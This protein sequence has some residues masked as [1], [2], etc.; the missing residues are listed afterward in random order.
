M[1]EVVNGETPD[2][3]S[4]GGPEDLRL[5]AAEWGLL[6]LLAAMQF[7]HIVDF[8]IIMPL[9]PVYIEK[10][11]LRPD[12]FG[13]MVSAYTISA[14]LAS[15]LAARFLD[16]FDRKITLLVLYAGFTVGTLLCAAAPTFV[17][18]VAARTV[19]GAFGGVTAAVVYAIVGDAFPHARRGTAMSVLMY[20]FSVATIFGVPIGLI[21]A[22]QLG[23]QAP[24]VVLGLLSV[25]MLAVGAVVLPPLR[26]HLDGPR[27]EEVSTWEVAF[28]PNHV[29]AFLLMLALV[30][31]S[32][33]VFPFVSTFLTFNVHM[34]QAYLKYMYLCGGLTTL[35]TLTLFGR[36]A[37]RFGKLRVFRIAAVACLIPFVGTPLI[38][39]GA[40]LP[41]I[42][43]VTTSMFV[44]SSG[45]MVPAMALITNSAEPRVRGS[46]MSYN[47]AV[48]QLGA[49]IA[50][51]VSGLLIEQVGGKEGPLVGYP[52]TGVLAGVAILASLYLAGRLRPA[53]GGAAAPDE[54]AVHPHPA[55]EPRADGILADPKAWPRIDPSSGTV[56]AGGGR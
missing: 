56:R 7:T 29:R 30:A 42:L 28:E 6:L 9:G 45:R 41:L 27:A 19:A 49:G 12:Q 53:P 37:D 4:A 25:G 40:G 52:L 50:S 22:E 21:L 15:L 46:F 18:L 1:A 5:S 35:F 31:S 39:E 16:R 48:Q 17:L 2:P 54:E 11:G 23:W 47:S 26:G 10:M 55:A 13:L 32:F 34:P 43:L 24:F 36:L 8:M 33:L 14:G 51:W 3:L 38:P 20:G 44:F